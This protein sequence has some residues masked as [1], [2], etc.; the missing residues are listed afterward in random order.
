MADAKAQ[1]YGSCRYLFMLFTRFMRLK[2]LSC[3]GMI[4]EKEL[5]RGFNRLRVL[6][7]EFP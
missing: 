7:N 1:S 2:E 3:K 4:G 5:G 6:R